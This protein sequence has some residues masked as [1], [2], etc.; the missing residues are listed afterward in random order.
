MQN[1]ESKNHT[2]LKPGD[3]VAIISVSSPVEEEVEIQKARAL[4]ESWGLNVDLPEDVNKRH[5]IFTGDDLERARR[6]EKYVLDDSIKALFFTRG[7]YGA[8]R[9]IKHLNQDLFQNKRKIVVGYSDV[10]TLLLYLHR[11][12]D[13]RIFHGP[14]VATARMFDAKSKITQDSLFQNLFE[15]EYRPEY[16]LK[17]IKPGNTTGQLIGG[18]LTLF[19]TSIGTEFEIETQGKILFIED[20]HKKPHYIDR[21][22]THLENAGKFNDIKGIVFAD[23]VGCFD[24]AGVLESILKE[25]FLGYTFPVVYGV[26]SGHGDVCVTLELERTVQIDSDSK[27]FKFI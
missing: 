5:L 27:S 7:G 2:Y 4:F 8:A 1:R 20:V 14:N 12:S 24:E 22:L 21:L 13:A 23:M 6:F 25:K 17:I 18:N 26:Q 9:I 10:T 15:P 16:K 3:K 19:S 11:F